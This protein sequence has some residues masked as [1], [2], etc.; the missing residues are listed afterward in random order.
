MYASNINVTD[1]ISLVT[2]NDFAIILVLNSKHNQR[3]ILHEREDRK[4][5]L[6]YLWGEVESVGFLLVVVAWVCEGR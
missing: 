6:I 2:L 5:S 1:G 3:G 4:R